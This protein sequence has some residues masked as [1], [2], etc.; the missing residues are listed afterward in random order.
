MHLKKHEL[1]IAAYLEKFPDAVLICE[2]SKKSV[3]LSVKSGISAN[4]E[5]RAEQ[6]THGVACV[7]CGKKMN[8]ITP[9]HLRKHQLTMD[10]Y[11]VANPDAPME[12]Q[13]YRDKLSASLIG[14]VSPHKGRTKE[15]HEYIARMAEERSKN[16]NLYLKTVQDN[17]EKK[18]ELMDKAHTA[19]NE[20]YAAGNFK[21]WNDGLTKETDDR[22]KLISD[23]LTGK[24]FTDSHKK[25]ISVSRKGKT[26]EQIHGANHEV[27]REKIRD[28]TVRRLASEEGF[29]K[30]DT[31]PERI[32]E[33]ELIRRG[34][35]YEKQ[36]VIRNK[37]GKAFTV[38]DFKVGDLYV[39]VDGD[40]WHG[41]PRL[42]PVLNASQIKTQNA[43]KRAVAGLT[44]MGLKVV[45]VWESAVKADASA[46][47][48]SLVT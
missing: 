20:S 45:R 37:R 44:A 14:R 10:Q 13:A 32:F 15:S 25:A 35:T 41:N 26:Y 7:I 24:P 6:E 46:V 27:V 16:P 39:Y 23:N 38:I 42:F 31:E 22:L 47:I 48:A 30:F 36:C 29:C 11:R 8:R 40:Y 1:T 43:D 5:K 34:L 2:A 18:Q 19:R 17:P 12:S 9:T 3:S 28:A 4:K 21:M 33:A